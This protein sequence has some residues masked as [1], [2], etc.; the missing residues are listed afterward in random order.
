MHED[1]NTVRELT[2][3][4]E[5]FETFKN[6]TRQF[7][8]AFDWR[9]SDFIESQPN[10]NESNGHLLIEH[11][12]E[13]SALI[14]FMKRGSS[15]NHLS[16]NNQN[17]FL[18]FSYNNLVDW[19]LFFDEN[20]LITINNRVKPVWFDRINAHDADF[21]FWRADAFKKITD[22]IPNPNIKKLDDALISTI[23]RW[24]R[25]IASELARDINDGMITTLFNAIIIVRAIE[26]QYYYASNESQRVLLDIHNDVSNDELTIKKCIVRAI[27]ELGY[28][29][30]PDYILNL[31]EL[32]VFNNLSFATIHDLFGDF[33][34][35]YYA[36]YTYDFSVISKNALSRIYERYITVLQ[37]VESDQ[38]SLFS[39]IP[40]EVENHHGTY[41]TPQYISRFFIKFLKE[42]TT[43]SNFRTQRIIDPACGSGIF[44]RTALEFI[45]DLNSDL[46]INDVVS[47][48][49]TNTWGYDKDANAINASKLSLSLLHII[50]AKKFPENLNTNCIN[51]L[52]EFSPDGAGRNYQESFDVVLANPPFIKWEDNSVDTQQKIKEILG[53]SAIGRNDLY[54][55]FLRIGMNLVSPGGFLL[56]VL[57]QSF[58]SNKSATAL[59]TIIKENFWIHYYVDLSEVNVFQE[60]G[61]Y[62]MLLILQK[63][64]N[65]PISE[66][67][68]VVVECKDFPGH[69]LQDAL[70]GYRG[71]KKFYRIYECRQSDF[72]KNKWNPQPQREREIISRVKRFGKLSDFMEVRQGII[73][74]N[75]QIFIRNKTDIHEDDAE[76]YIP[77]LP[78]REMRPYK[79]PDNTEKMIFFPFRKGV[80]I[81]E[82]DLQNIFPDTWEYLLSNK[83]DLSRSKSVLSGRTH[84]WKPVWPR[85]PKVILRPKIATPHL[86]FMPKFSIDTQGKYGISH[87]PMLYPKIE[88]NELIVIKYCTAVLNSSI[89]YWQ[90]MKLSSKYSRGYL[91]LENHTLKEFSIPHPSEI[92]QHILK[93]LIFIVDKI[94]S[95][96]YNQEYSI[97]I[98]NIVRS[99]YQITNDESIKLGII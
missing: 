2:Q 85:T 40:I 12:L 97:E 27:S 45:C 83:E 5:S 28:D 8:K 64:P 25:L 84:W 24:K 9:P 88:E 35:N 67:E 71:D 62:T 80:L 36:P 16:Y 92:S 41:Y 73:T 82:V 33:Y 99:I 61:I 37:R 63:K 65:Y 22:R 11:G 68:A 56:Y 31:N 66:P 43:P 90:L 32:A 69:A 29:S 57:P 23:S 14:T 96:E 15:F 38:T 39:E 78:D 50:L 87:S 48:A 34:D 55:A 79:I 42:N 17:S 74:G 44:L 93:D 30:I 47:A 72:E 81:N 21:Q 77:Y 94:L 46:D 10:D 18:S 49:Y 3:P 59:R 76:L 26:D 86:I 91:R 60:A 75:D 51:S 6:M 70:G 95:E 58:V 13:C 53:E 7:A 89:G 20:G 4:I 52:E 98:D 54:H 1:F 19:H